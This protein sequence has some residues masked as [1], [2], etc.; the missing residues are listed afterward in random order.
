MKH[1]AALGV[2]L[3]LTLQTTIS[4]AQ[5]WDD[6][7]RIEIRQMENE[8]ESASRKKH[9]AP[10]QYLRKLFKL[11]D[12]YY[13]SQ[14]YASARTLYW[15]YFL[16][17]IAAGLYNL[18]N[19]DDFKLLLQHAKCSFYLGDYEEAV[20]KFKGWMGQLEEEGGLNVYEIAAI[21]WITDCYVKMGE[22]TSANL[23]VNKVKEMIR[24]HSTTDPY[25]L[26]LA[27]YIEADLMVHVDPA[28]AVAHLERLTS[29]LERLDYAQLESIEL[30]IAYERLFA[31]CAMRLALFDVAEKKEKNAIMSM[32][33]YHRTKCIDYFDAH[34]ELMLIKSL[35]ADADSPVVAVKLNKITVDFI[36]DNFPKMTER[37]R[38]AYWECF[39][40]WLLFY[41]PRLATGTHAKKS[42]PELVADAYSGIILAKGMLL[43]S[44][45]SLQEFVLHSNDE[46]LIEMLEQVQYLKKKLH[47]WQKSDES[48]AH[49]QI[50]NTQINLDRLQQRMLKASQ[51]YDFMAD[52]RVN[53]DSVKNVLERGDVAIEIIG[54]DCDV[55]EED[56]TEIR[57]KEYYAFVI[58]P[59]YS[60]PHIVFLCD[61]RALSQ[62]NDVSTL[63]GTI[64][65]PLEGELKGTRRV[66]FSPDAELHNFP[67]EHCITPDGKLI[68]ER[69]ALYRLSSTGQ[70][71]NGKQRVKNGDRAVIFGDVD[72]DGG[73]RTKNG[74]PRG[75][76]GN[77]G[78]GEVMSS[79]FLPLDNSRQEIESVASFCRLRGMD[80]QLFSQAD[81]SEEKFKALSGESPDI[82]LLSTHG[83]YIPK[84]SPE[85]QSTR[86]PV[87]DENAEAVSLDEESLSRSGLVLAGANR[88]LMGED[89]LDDEEDGFLTGREL[90]RMNLDNTDLVVLSACE[91]ALGDPSSEGVLGLQYGF[92]RA[93][94]QSLLVSL[95]KVNDYA[96]SLFV[97]HFFQIYLDPQK[98][99]TKREAFNQ[100][101]YY[102][103]TTESGRWN[104]P[105]YWAAFILLDALDHKR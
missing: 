4:Y 31:H 97:R 30:L 33:K 28:D 34:H 100:T 91:T 78:A 29:L 40:S 62:R 61:S 68:A 11:A 17:S 60:V 98:H 105:E 36:H 19:E 88:Y 53:I 20:D 44:A 72:Y 41:Q 10:A 3:L 8:V 85:K 52:V 63:Y 51:K 92:K 93:G 58:R 75:K 79:I 81:A 45:N 73:E 7:V 77:R 42:R 16:Q 57:V 2:V 25:V 50:F 76:S 104:K 95:W 54:L 6:S 47:Q 67:I 1:L 35:N 18:E 101:I 90:C 65:H 86:L 80:T 43:R 69:Y 83:Y 39:K 9:K 71:V 87:D 37:Q 5:T 23:G 70:L 12:L 46:E 89:V 21:C 14:D 24:E 56:S 13:V 55:T 27:E 15:E 64:W 94:A 102:L 48:E 99:L 32:E 103:R 26:A 84:S 38:S 22:Y 59:E 66:F 96:T 49:Q 74:E 82:L